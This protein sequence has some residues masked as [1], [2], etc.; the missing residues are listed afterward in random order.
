MT[1]KITRTITRETGS[2]D[3]I[4]FEPL[5]IRLEPGFPC[6]RI[7]CKNR[8]HKYSVSFQAIYQL[9]IQAEARAHRERKSK[10]R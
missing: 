4:D 10:R 7:W 3:N 9:A 1:R 5:M 6:L 8:R 2:V